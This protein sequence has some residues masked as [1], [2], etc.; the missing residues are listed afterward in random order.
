MLG[1]NADVTSLEK[2]SDGSASQAAIDLQAKQ[3]EHFYRVANDKHLL[4]SGLYSRAA[5]LRRHLLHDMVHARLAWILA[6]VRCWVEHSLSST[7]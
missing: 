4:P 2:L 3:F 5:S 6:Q 1:H 7:I